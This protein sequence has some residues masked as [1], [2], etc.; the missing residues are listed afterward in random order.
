[1]TELVTKSLGEL[2]QSGYIVLHSNGDVD[3]TSMGEIMSY[4]YLSHMTTRH[5]VTR[6]KRDASFQDV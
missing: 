4:S 1:M 2:A 5:L 6:A 3:S